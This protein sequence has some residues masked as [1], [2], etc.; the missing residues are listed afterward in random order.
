MIELALSTF[1]TLFVVLDPPGIGPVFA[2]LSEGETEDYKRRLALRGTLT[3]TAILI[4]FA[5][6]GEWIL[7][8]LGVTIDSFRIAGGLFLFLIAVDMLFAHETGLRRTTPDE[9]QEAIRRH[10]ISI[11]PIA[12][13]LIAGPGAMT[14]VVLLM[15]QTNGY[16]YR[17]AVVLLILVL[18]MMLV[19]GALAM[20][21]RLS[22]MMGVTGT[23][24]ITRV[25]GVILGALA[26]Q[27]IIDGL[28][29]AFGG[30]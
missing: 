14:S 19:W 16:I 28:L 21:V 13:P 9:T 7:R 4:G 2:A 29:G 22:R 18:V 12:I 3:A 15:Q 5:F 6:V 11:F 30:E 23:N 8:M 20:S 17:Q 27:Y 26:V 25:L 1:V 10:D 24:V